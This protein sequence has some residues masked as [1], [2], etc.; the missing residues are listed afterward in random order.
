MRGQAQRRCSDEDAAQGDA[1]TGSGEKNDHTDPTIDAAW[2]IAV[3]WRAS[4][5]SGAARIQGQK[6]A[7][8]VIAKDEGCRRLSEEKQFD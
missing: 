3:A 4:S 1:S 5:S 7:V 2:R 6:V 8:A